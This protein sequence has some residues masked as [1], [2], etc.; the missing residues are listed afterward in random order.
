MCFLLKL[1]CLCLNTDDDDDTFFFFSFW[2]IIE[3]NDTLDC[4]QQV[5]VTAHCSIKVEFAIKMTLW[6]RRHSFSYNMQSKV[7]TTF[8]C[9]ILNIFCTHI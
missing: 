9:L 3:I 2:S 6:K 4:K 7:L 8:K 1:S 5:P